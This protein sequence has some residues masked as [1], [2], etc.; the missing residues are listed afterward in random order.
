M[1][2]VIIIIIKFEGYRM[3]NSSLCE[4]ARPRLQ[5]SRLRLKKIETPRAVIF[6]SLCPVSLTHKNLQRCKIIHGMHP[7][8]MHPVGCEEGSIDL[9][10]CICR[11]SP[12]M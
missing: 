12:F 11:N 6:Q 4:T 2:I 10:M 7:H 3:V 8:G 9:N 1:R 5:D